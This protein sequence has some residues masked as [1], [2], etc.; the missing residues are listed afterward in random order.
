MI[1]RISIN[2]TDGQTDRENAI[3]Y[4]ASVY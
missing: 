4:R 2:N 3:S 1:R